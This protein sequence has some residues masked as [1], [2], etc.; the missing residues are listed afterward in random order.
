[1]QNLRSHQPAAPTSPHNCHRMSHGGTTPQ[2]LA[3]GQ[4]QGASSRPTSTN[5]STDPSCISSLN[6]LTSTMNTSILLC[7]SSICRPSV[8]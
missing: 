1:M 8:L 6:V 3:M 7:Q 2:I 4:N 5:L